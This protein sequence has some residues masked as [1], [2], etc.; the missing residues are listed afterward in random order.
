MEKIKNIANYFISK[1]KERKFF[2]YN[3]VFYK[4]RKVYEGSIRL[5]IYLFIADTVYLARYNSKL[6]QEDFSIINNFPILKEIVN[7]YSLLKGNYENINNKEK[8]FLDKI[9]FSL[10]NASY[11]ELIDIVLEDSYN[12]LILNIEDN[13]NVY[14]KKYNGIIEALRI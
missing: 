2:N 11:D 6:F 9:Y 1:D 10:E 13:V 3:N 8:V 12:K 5:S 14:K 4:D 7:S